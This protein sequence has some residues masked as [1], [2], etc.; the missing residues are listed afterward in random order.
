MY[1][2]GKPYFEVVTRGPENTEWLGENI[3]RLSTAGNIYL[4]I[5]NLGVGKTSLVRGIAHGLGVKGYISSPSFVLIKEFVGRVPL[6][7]IDLYRLED[8]SEVAALGLEDYLYGR[9]VTAVEWADRAQALFSGDELIIRM[10][11]SAELGDN[12]RRIFF[13]PSGERYAKLVQEIKELIKLSEQI[14]VTC[15]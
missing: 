8:I 10:E 7:H 5:G 1:L 11:Y 6:Y 14:D 13:Y 9:G 4:L 2:S 3:G 15:H 12:C